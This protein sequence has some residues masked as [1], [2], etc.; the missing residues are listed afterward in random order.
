MPRRYEETAARSRPAKRLRGI[1]YSVLRTQ[2]PVP[3]TQ[4]R[5]PCA[6]QPIP[7]RNAR[8][9]NFK[10]RL[11][12]RGATFLQ[13]LFGCRGKNCF[14]ILMYHRVAEVIPGIPEPTWNVTP[15]RFQEQLRGLLDRGFEAWPLR[16]VLEFHQAEKPI[17]RQAFAVTFD[18]GYECVYTQAWPILKKLHLP[19]TLFLSTAYLD[20]LDPF[21]CDDWRAAG[22]PHV[23]RDSWQ[24]LTT[25]QCREMQAGGLIEL[26]AHTHTHDD[27]RGRPADLRIDHGRAAR[28]TSAGDRSCRA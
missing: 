21:P 7:R 24:P 13:S 15:Q 20:S 17:P 18:D 28:G 19:A 22:E 25:D 14:G 23:P 26:A 8:V 12:L 5:P 6:I 2:Y 11:L 10:E 4:S 27:F 16:K 3:S 9:P 1:R